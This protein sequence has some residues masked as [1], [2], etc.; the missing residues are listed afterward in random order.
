MGNPSSETPSGKMYGKRIRMAALVDPA[1]YEALKLL[2][3]PDDGDRWEAPI[4]RKIIREWLATR[5]QG[6]AQGFGHHEDIL[7]ADMRR[8][9][10]EER[11]RI[12]REKKHGG[13]R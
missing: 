5:G 6:Q 12:L 10:E 9:L 3:D 13:G 1:T 8:Q 7:T 4:L 11:Q 2:R